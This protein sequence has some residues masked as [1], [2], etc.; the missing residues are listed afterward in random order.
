MK[1]TALSA[2]SL[3]LLSFPA[4]SQDTTLA[5]FYPLHVGDYWE[6]EITQGYITTLRTEKVL[7]DTIIACHIYY[8]VRVEDFRTGRVD[9]GYGRVTATG[10]IVTYDFNTAKEDTS[11]F[12]LNMQAG[13]SSFT[14]DSSAVVVFLGENWESVFGESRRVKKFEVSDYPGV[15]FRTV[16]GFAQGLGLV[17]VL[18]PIDGAD[19]RLRGAIISGVRYGVVSTIVRKGHESDPE[20]FELD[21]NH[22][23]PFNNSTSIQYRLSKP[24]NVTLRVYNLQSQQIKLLIRGRQGAGKHRVLWDGTNE[25]GDRVASGIY[26]CELRVGSWRLQKKMLVIR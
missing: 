21:Q 26:I 20:A 19:E 22:P 17:Y 13:D 18:G 2:L 5:S 16:Y 10:E 9:S 7:S 6:Y 8:L 12:R 11:I 15:L 25:R 3:L 4:Q 1:G 14:E 23:N 24:D